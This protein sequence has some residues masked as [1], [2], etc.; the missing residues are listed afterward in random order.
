[1]KPPRVVHLVP[2]PFGGTDGV[3]GGA[4][5]YA[6]ELARHMAEVVP[7]SLLTFGEADRVEWIGPLRRR[8][9]RS[10]WFVRGQRSNPLAAAMLGELA[11]ADVI[12]C[13]QQHIAASSLAAAAARLARRR[14]FVTDLGGG[15]FD[16]SGYISTDSWY[17]GHLH[18]SRYSRHVSGH[19]GRSGAHVIGGGVDIEV[20]RPDPARRRDGT[21]IAVGR[22][23]PHKGTNYVI[24]AV[25]DRTPVEIIGRE[26][27]SRFLADLQQMARGK[28]VVF[29]H[30]ADD[31]ALVTAY[32][33]AGCVVQASVYR[34]M[35][36]NETKVPELLGL[37]LI[38]AMACGAPCICT[39][40]ASLPEVVEDGV[41]GLVV[42]P[43]DPRALGD[44]IRRILSRPEESARMGE[45][46][47]RRVLER[48]T[49]P[50]VVERCLRIYTAPAGDW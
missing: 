6:F 15:G 26:A 44:A 49:W 43:N 50:A 37:T 23:L 3:T 30:D 17:H 34:D 24:E 19:D 11:R 7:T 48:F 16:V 42:P 21:V 32:R 38:E 39:S 31:T 46:G 25:D 33:R 4:E 8:I 45:A 40:V 36:G 13:H 27:D 2:A 9:L 14:V 41:T 47:R 12:H 20:F 29:R 18:I 28:R 10:R 1:M 22:L 5:R 35:Y